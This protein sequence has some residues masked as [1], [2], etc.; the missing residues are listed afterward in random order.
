MIFLCKSS[1]CLIH[2]PWKSLIVTLIN[3][4][5]T[6]LVYIDEIHLFV[7]F[8]ITSHKECIVLKILF[9]QH[10]LTNVD[11]RY[12]YAL[13]LYKSANLVDDSSFQLINVESVAADDSY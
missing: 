10:I 2:K 8:D 7:M 3:R 11:L 6:K 9:S 13:G 5:V 4:R 12:I 1:E